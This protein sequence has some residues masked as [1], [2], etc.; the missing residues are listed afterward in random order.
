MNGLTILDIIILILFLYFVI[1][2]YNKGFIRQT[3][4]ILGLIIALLV[5]IKQYQDFEGFLTPYLEVSPPL[6]SFISFSIIF[7][8]FNIVIHI[9]GISLKKAT[10]FLFLGPVDSIAGAFLGFLKSGILVYL[11]IYILNEVPHDY[12]INMLDESYFASNILE[13][14]PVIQQN[15]NKMFGQN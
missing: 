14:T 5:A 9:L 7:I 4:K 15:L 12:V 1:K 3:S 2:G 11:I 13:L 10:N 8:V 6:L